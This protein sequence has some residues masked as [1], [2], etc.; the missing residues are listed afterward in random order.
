MNQSAKVWN[1]D[2]YAMQIQI[3]GQIPKKRDYEHMKW[4]RTSKNSPIF[5]YLFLP[6]TLWALRRS[7]KLYA[8]QAKG[9]MAM[10]P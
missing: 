1:Y 3:E 6:F 7:W 5:L 9:L 4:A 2:G 8:N 10:Q